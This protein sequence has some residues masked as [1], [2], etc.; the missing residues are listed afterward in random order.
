MLT[1]QIVLFDGFDLLDAMAPYEVFCAASTIAEQELQVEFVTA[2]GPRLVTSGI[3]GLQIEATGGLNP[4]RADIILVPGAAGDVEGDG[5]DSIPAILNRAANTELTRLIQQAL[6]KGDVVVATVCGGSLLL[7]MK[8]L[9]EGRPAVTHHLGMDVLGAAGA[10]PVSARVVDDGNLVSGG[11]VTS[12]LDVA[13]YLLERELGPR[14]AHAVEQLFEYERRGTVWREKGIAPSSQKRW[15]DEEPNIAKM[16]SGTE[17]HNIAQASVFDGEWDTIIV[18]PVGSLPVRLSIT[19]KNGA[20]QGTALQGDEAV[21]FMNP[22]LQD[23]KL[24]WSLRI[25]K[26]MRLN[27]KF[28]VA[29]EGDHMTGIAKAGVLPASRLTGIRIS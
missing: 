19:T 11:G 29:A 8:G 9:L 28:E 27:L 16:T 18:T 23:N 12:G 1:V 21:T 2:E 3:N 15:Q 6:G 20:I 13:L 25:T 5:P 4:E 22:V 7:A 26:P 17:H 24:A 14:I 10:I